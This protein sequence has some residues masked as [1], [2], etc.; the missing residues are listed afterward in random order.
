[1]VVLLTLAAFPKQVRAEVKILRVPEHGQVPDVRLDAKGLLHL[2][3]G[4]G[5][6]GNGF[7]VQS[8][9]LGKTFTK[10]V[11]LNRRP[12]TVTTG[13]E[14]GPKLAL[15]R[16]GTIH[17]LWHG[18]YKNGGGVWYTRST[19]GGTTFEAERD[20]VNPSYGTDNAAIAADADGNVFA[21][22]TGGFP[23]VKP[24][25]DSPVA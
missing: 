12:D 22:W 7:Y 2:T 17:V 6:P 10:P 23:G 24:D 13:M 18:F 25:P 16:D 1:M 20:L 15:G 9:D 3:Y 5:A 14:R 21:L 19:D 8:R 11:Q 4:L